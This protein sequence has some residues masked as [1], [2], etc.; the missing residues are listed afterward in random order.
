[1]GFL[2]VLGKV[3]KVSEAVGPSVATAINPAAGALVSLVVH[4]VTEAEQAG[5]TGAEKK[6]AAVKSVLPA[7]TSVVTAAIQA[8]NPK[9]QLDPAQLSNAVGNLVDGVVALM[10]SVQPAA[11]ATSAGAAGAAGASSQGS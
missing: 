10:N 5:G 11:A 9:A 4:S 8:K 7:A 6:V 2:N 3:L 1:M